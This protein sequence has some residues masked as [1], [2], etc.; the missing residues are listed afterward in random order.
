M[1]IVV[2]LSLSWR[3]KVSARCARCGKWLA[4]RYTLG[5]LLYVHLICT[6]DE[7]KAETQTCGSRDKGL[8]VLPKCEVGTGGSRR[9]ESI[10]MVLQ[11]WGLI[12]CDYP[13]MV[14]TQT[15]QT[16]PSGTRT[17]KRAVYVNGHSS[18]EPPR[19]G[20]YLGVPRVRPS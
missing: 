10:F 2:P 18:V 8:G 3:C 19:S 7:Q 4:S 15:K 1:E 12:P 14:T 6:M 13:P 16:K 17:G 5:I 9:K 11:T 20:A